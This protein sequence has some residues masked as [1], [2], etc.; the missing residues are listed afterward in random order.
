MAKINLIRMPFLKSSAPKCNDKANP[1]FYGWW[2]E[3]REYR[4][5]HEGWGLK[6]IFWGQLNPSMI[7]ATL[8]LSV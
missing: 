4:K 7:N 5:Q 3:G 2:E 6:G 8:K 1:N